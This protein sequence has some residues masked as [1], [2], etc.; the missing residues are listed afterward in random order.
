[1]AFYFKKSNSPVAIGALHYFL[2]QCKVQRGCCK[3]EFYFQKCNRVFL[4]NGLVWEGKNHGIG[5]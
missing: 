2:Q 4:V 5:K 3:M 1:M